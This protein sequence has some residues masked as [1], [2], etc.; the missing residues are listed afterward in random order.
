MLG[1]EKYNTDPLRSKGNLAGGS[2]LTTTSLFASYLNAIGLC[3]KFRGSSKSLKSDHLKKIVLPNPPNF[4]KN[5]LSNSFFAYN[6][7]CSDLLNITPKIQYPIFHI[8]ITILK[9]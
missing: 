9:L 1:S 6:A 4:S 7:F 3:F 8:T 5:I 2:I